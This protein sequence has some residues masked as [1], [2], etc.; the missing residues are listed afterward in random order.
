MKDVVDS[1]TT[2]VAASARTGKSKG[3]SIS[4][5]ATPQLSSSGKVC[6]SMSVH[7][8]PFIGVMIAQLSA[9]VRVR[10]DGSV[11]EGKLTASHKGLGTTVDDLEAADGA[12]T[13]LSTT[14]AEVETILDLAELGPEFSG[15]EGGGCLGKA[16]CT[17]E[18]MFYPLS[19]ALLETQR[20]C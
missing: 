7:S 13:R 2:S 19:Q 16:H 6:H 8:V 12:V 15:F 4:A 18:N 9:A 10:R 3:G 14:L 5:A 11:V 20:S 17:R 1:D